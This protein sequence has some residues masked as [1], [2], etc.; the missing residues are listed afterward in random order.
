MILPF[1]HYNKSIVAVHKQLSL[2]NQMMSYD[3]TISWANQN[4]Q[5]HENS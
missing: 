3:H 5:A 2:M 1:E 4:W